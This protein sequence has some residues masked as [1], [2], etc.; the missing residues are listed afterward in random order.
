MASDVLLQS[1]TDTEFNVM[2]VEACE[3]IPMLER[4]FSNVAFEL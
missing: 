2:C 4:H 1:V 3:S